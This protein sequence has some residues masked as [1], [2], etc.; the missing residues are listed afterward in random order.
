MKLFGRKRDDDAEEQAGQDAADAPGTAG[1]DV[2]P[3]AWAL[4]AD[5]GAAVAPET[6]AGGATPPPPDPG[7]RSGAVPPPDPSARVAAMPPPAAAAGTTPP[8]DALRGD[9]A[10]ESAAAADP[11]PR[12]EGESGSGFSVPGLPENLNERPELLIG[13]AFAGAF[14][15]ARILKRITD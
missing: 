9:T 8:A 10:A 2:D 1:S 7:A 6:A 4:P 11:E 13:G 14:L 15:F 5:A 12:V 3:G